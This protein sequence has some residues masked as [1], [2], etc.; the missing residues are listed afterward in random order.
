MAYRKTRHITILPDVALEL[1]R[2]YSIGEVSIILKVSLRTIRFYCEKKL[3]A[4]RTKTTERY[5]D[6]H[7]IKR[8]C[9]VLQGKLL[10]F[11]LFDISTL[12][13]DQLDAQGGPA[14]VIPEDMIEREIEALKQRNDLM[15]SIISK[16]VLSEVRAQPPRAQGPQTKLTLAG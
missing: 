1:G 2:L 10:G 16:S 12:I 4:D 6:A 8:L 3:I 15:L 13:V 14:L 5:F 7:N 9:L 11:S